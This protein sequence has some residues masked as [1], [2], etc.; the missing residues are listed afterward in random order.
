MT[1]RRSFESVSYSSTRYK[2][3]LTYV[4]EEALLSAYDRRSGELLLLQN[5]DNL[6]EDFE[7]RTALL[8]A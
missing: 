2:P 5:M 3:V 1:H 6:D 4:D 8:E 7:V